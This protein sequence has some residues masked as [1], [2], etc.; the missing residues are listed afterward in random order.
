MKITIRTRETIKF[1][2]QREILNTNKLFCINL[3]YITRF[4]V[5][6]SFIYISY[7]LVYR[8]IRAS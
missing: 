7:F 4:I 3:K 8:I 6:V 2:Q 1:I 5:I